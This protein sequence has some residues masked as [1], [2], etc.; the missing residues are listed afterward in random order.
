[1]QSSPIPDGTSAAQSSEAGFACDT[2]RQLAKEG[3][4][5]SQTKPNEEEKRAISS[6]KNS[7]KKRM[8]RTKSKKQVSFKRRKGSWHYCGSDCESPSDEEGSWMVLCDVC[9]EWYHYKCEKVTAQEM[10]ALPPED[11]YVCLKCRTSGKTKTR[12]SKSTKCVPPFSKH[13]TTHHAHTHT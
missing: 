3:V 7:S 6:W 1:M 10:K 12:S 11:D 13:N 8:R 9:V 4:P 2:T 5:S